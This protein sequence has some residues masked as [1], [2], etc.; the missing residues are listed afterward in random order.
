[1]NQL[2]CKIVRKKF[3]GKN[4][5]FE[6]NSIEGTKKYIIP[7]QQLNK[8]N[9]KIGETYCFEKKQNINSKKYFLE[10]VQD[11]TDET[12]T[13]NLNYL[14]N[15]IYEFQIIKFD[16]ELNRKSELIQ[17][18][19][20]KDIDGNE[21]KV[22]CL[23]W[24]NESIWKFKNLFCL[25]KGFSHNG[26]PRLLVKDDRHPI[27]EIN[28]EYSFEIIRE[29]VKTTDLG[30]YNV[31][32]IKGEDNCIHE[33]NILP[34][35]KI[36]NQDLQFVKCKV[37]NITTNLRLVQMGVKDP[38]YLTFEKIIPEKKLKL[39]YFD[40]YFEVDNL[41][42]KYEIQLIEQYNSF[43]A[44]WVFTY[45]NKILPKLL[46]ESN[47]KL[48][49]K[50]S[51]EINHL[52]INFEE[53]ILNK[54]IIAS[55][56][57]EEKKE[58]T[59][60]RA[61]Q[62]L[63]SS[64]TIDYVL[65][66]LTTNPYYYLS[67]DEY[68]DDKKKS[69]SIL[70]YLI[71]FSKIEIIDTNLLI[72]RLQILL[73]N[74][75]ISSKS[76]MFYLN[77]LLNYISRNK[78]T[79]ISEEEKE[80][81]SLS[82]SKISD[83]NFTSNENK[84]IIWSYAEILISKE[85]SKNEHSNILIGQLLKLF[86]KSTT[87]IILKENLLYNS[88]Y[89]FENYQSK[90]LSIPFL[91]EKSIQVVYDLLIPR[92]VKHGENWDSLEDFFNRKI[93]F[94]VVLTKK[95]N[96]GYEVNYN[97]LRGFLPYHHIKDKILKSY[98]FEEANFE[99]D[100]NCISISKEFDF[101]IIEQSNSKF[102]NNFETN[103]KIV[104]GEIH[105]AI[106]KSVESY[107]LFLITSIGEGLLY[108]KEIFDFVWNYSNINDYFNAGQKIKVVLQ[109]INEEGK[110]EFNFFNIKNTFPLYYDDYVERIFS[111]DTDDLFDT[112][113][114]IIEDTYFEIALNEKA[115][116]IE[117]YAVL[118][119]D[120]NEKLKNLQI[121]K[122]FYTN[123][124]NAR[125]FLINVY[126]SYFE[127]LSKIKLT[128]QNGTF[129]D[130]DNIKK[131]AEEIKDKINKRT[132]EIF[133]DSDKLI[134]FLDI[135][136]KFNEKT[137]NVLN[138]L[139]DYIKKYSNEQT[140]NELKIIAKITLANNLLLSESKIDIDF[141]LKNLRLIF[142]YISN[143]ILSLEET[144]EDKYAREVKEELLIW[145]ERIKED[146][147]ETLEF[148]S[149][150]FLPIPDEKRLKR[151][152]ELKIIEKQTEQHKNEISRINGELAK[153]CVIH[154]ALKTLVAFANHKGGSLLIG[155]N[156]SKK[157]IG[158]EQEYKTFPKKDQ[159]RD[160]FGKYF[161]GLVRTYIGDSFS[162]LMNRKFLKF[163]EGD[164]LIITIQ[165]SNEEVFLLKNEEGKDVHQLYIRNLSSS[166]ELLGIEL[167][168]FIKN[169]Q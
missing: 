74:F 19:Y 136:S 21:I 97:N 83:T 142:D 86:T 78:K 129:E 132:I 16:K 133:P 140:N 116:C 9:I 20:V 112:Q 81:F 27:Y 70:Y 57:N 54:G 34:I 73:L 38:F 93:D 1:M 52:I 127:I 119:L 82:S 153:K 135:I 41:N 8:F 161:D 37:T 151:L 77:G 25:V 80:N 143:G 152:E 137:D 148:K 42:D 95:S 117:Q 166:K 55:F 88:Y 50:T 125:S 89:Y 11:E 84:Y 45:A 87:E 5:Y 67:K 169:R 66:I 107:G 15:E 139:F 91:Y 98:P 131:N 113:K 103:T 167:V 92:T 160:G 121:A 32:E 12:F 28:K 22:A 59:T 168:K 128:I 56:P 138:L 51:K 79:F 164:I 118:Q 61:K 71:I 24:Q 150:L 115:Y 26:V 36:T 65:N 149:T 30:T 23:K 130:I 108:K 165:P 146:E 145:E 124:K 96:T 134:Y 44:F 43:S 75:D 162:S 101:F 40:R 141:S 17:V 3:I 47:E 14:E 33:V 7:V 156:D 63:E 46:K 94:K 53:W 69:F 62:Q 126:T 123:A 109:K 68:F 58:Y 120:L 158:L 106:V 154:S 104:Q 111:Y 2:E 6:V 147:S 60:H 90:E 110:F 39:K 114:E 163:P 102:V 76:N 29:K 35:Q 105:D 99:I 13:S 72:D 159:N 10:F 100:A 122:Q 85:L 48:D 157:V 31:Y 155:V 49:Y 18:V 144:I 64:K 4:E